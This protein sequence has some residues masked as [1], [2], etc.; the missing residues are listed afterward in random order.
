MAFATTASQER[1]ALSSGSGWWSAATVYQIYPRSFADADGDGVGDLSGIVSKIPYLTALGVDAIWISPF[2]PSAGADAGYDVSDPCAIDPQFGTFD[3]FDRIVALAH[4]ANI[5]VI[6]DVVPNHTSSEHR[7][8]VDALAARA[9]SAARSRYIFRPGRGDGPP[10]DWESVFGGPAWTRVAGSDDWYLHLFDRE[11]PDLNWRNPE[12]RDEY[13][14]VL[15]FWLDRGVDGFRID[16]AHG[17]IKAEGLPDIGTA[18][19]NPVDA[20][21]DIG[22]MWDQDEVH[23]IYRAWRRLLAEYGE[24]RILVAEAWPPHDRLG[25]YIRP[26]EMHQAFNFRYL[27]AG[28]DAANVSS[29]ID[30]SLTTTAEVGATTTWVLSNHDIVRVVSRLGREDSTS[31]TTGIGPDEPQPDLELGRQRARAYTLLTLALP[32]S[33][34]IYQGEELGLPEHTTMPSHHRRDPMHWRTSGTEVGR[35]GC[36]VPLPWQHDAPGYGFGP[37]PWLPQ[38]RVF[39]DLAVDRQVDDPR[40]FLHFYRSALR[41]RRELSL[42][43]TPIVSKRVDGD[44]LRIEKDDIAVLVNFSRAPI[45]VGCAGSDLVLATGPDDFADGVLAPNS[46]VWLR[47]RA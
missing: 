20:G 3:D 34:Y 37:T 35:D 12:V 6:I 29:T 25:K 23:E 32:G 1:G 30:A 2:Y 15:R 31:W 13:D 14:R 10:N 45:L 43:H 11:Q 5:R 39:G 28:W 24:D 41:I 19:T 36:R 40:S 16:V 8:F 26:D 4:D 46:A 21:G 9:D 17:L 27:A 38:P 22:P 7:W 44:V 42:G 33:A 18:R 47:R